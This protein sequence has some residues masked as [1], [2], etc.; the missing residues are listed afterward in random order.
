MKNCA[1]VIRVSEKRQGQKPDSSPESQRIQL[2]RYISFR[3][4]QVE[5][6]SD[7]KLV[8]FKEFRLVGVPG[9]ESFDSSEFAELKHDIALGMVNIVMAT[10]LDR[11]G[12]DVKKF[13]EFFEFLREHKVELVVTHYQIDTATPTGQLVITILMALAEMQREQ[14]SKKITISRH[15]YT[16]EKKRKSGGSVPL[17]F[18]LDPE[19]TGFFKVN[20]AEAAI[21]RAAFELYPLYGNL[22]KTAKELN[23]RGFTTKE[24]LNQK[25]ELRGGKPFSSETVKYILQNMIYIGILE[26]HKSNKGKP[27]TDVPEDERYATYIP[28]NPDDWPKLID[29]DV[30]RRV[31]TVLETQAPQNRKGSRKTYPY[32]LAGLVHCAVCGGLMKAEKGKDLHYYACTNNA[33]DSRKVIARTFPRLKRNSI[34]ACVLESAVQRLVQDIVLENPSEVAK[35]TRNVNQLL[36]GQAPKLKT[37][38]GSLNTKLE[39]L[40]ARKHGIQVALDESKGNQ[41]Q[42]VKLSKDLETVMDELEE[43][44]HLLA[45]KQQE[46]AVIEE[47]KVTEGAVRRALE[48]LSKDRSL[49]PE[50]QVKELYKTFFA[51]IKVGLDEIEAHL[52]IETILHLARMRPDPSSFDWC[53]GWY[54]R[55]ELNPEPSGP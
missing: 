9:N 14:L 26:E 15:I 50:E 33:C 31:Q 11:F 1:L 28:D 38:C 49:I 16:S 40:R 22:R 37:E 3:N 45:K 52:Q 36:A 5:E 39:R 35:L 48:L 55:Q 25:G 2:E 20:D 21:V 42:V 24:S 4:S 7:E 47:A 46:I 29:E 54:A 6:S 34:D 30:F 8:I 51:E 17:G 27:D 19:K 18:D 32:H 53:Q 23:R 13:L 12:R 41:K 44:E 43:L 10:G